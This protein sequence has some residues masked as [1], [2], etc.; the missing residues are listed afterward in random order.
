MTLDTQRA[1]LRIE[2]VSERIGRSRSWIWEAVK[3][4][5]FP[6]PIKLSTRCTRWDS[7]AVGRW[8]DAQ[9]DACLASGDAAGAE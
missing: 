5:D 4:G 8:I 1:L 7:L 6:A 9:L 2:R 3:R